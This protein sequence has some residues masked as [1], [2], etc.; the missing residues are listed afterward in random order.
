MFN[1]GKKG[2]AA[3][4][5]ALAHTEIPPNL[6]FQ[7]E[8]LSEVY[9][10][11]N[12][13]LQQAITTFNQAESALSDLVTELSPAHAE[14]LGKAE[15]A[16]KARIHELIRPYC[17]DESQAKELINQM[18]AVKSAENASRNWHTTIDL[19]RKARLLLDPRKI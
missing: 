16:L 12:P 4:N 3:L 5:T 19:A 9:S 8:Q 7:L 18:A 6:K 11:V 2:L 13:Q 17:A 15:T 10:Q 1:S 14:A